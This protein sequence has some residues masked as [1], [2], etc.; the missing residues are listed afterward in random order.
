MKEPIILNINGFRERY[1]YDPSQPIKAG[2]QGKIYKAKDRYRN[3]DV[4]IKRA[5][6]PTSDKDKYS[7]Y[8]EFQR[9]KT[10]PFHTNLAKYYDAYRF[11]TRMGDF[12][13][14]VMEFV[15]GGQNLDDFIKTFPSME[16]IHIVLTGI[17]EGIQHLHDNDVIHRDLKPANILVSRDDSKPIAKIIDFGISKE[18][19]RPETSVSAKV[20]TPEYMAPEQINNNRNSTYNIDLWSYGV[21]LYRLLSGEMPFGS[22]EN[23][24]TKEKIISQVIKAKIPNDIKRI[25][26]PYRTAIKRCLVKDNR[27]RAQSAKE[28]LDIL[29]SGVGPINSGEGKTTV[30][31]PPPPPEEPSPNPKKRRG[32]YSVMTALLLIALAGVLYYIYPR[33]NC[34]NPVDCFMNGQYYDSFQLLK[35]IEED[36]EF[37]PFQDYMMGWLYAQG[38]HKADMENA[39]IPEPSLAIEYLDRAKEANIAEA[40]VAHG[41]ILKLGRILQ[42]DTTRAK[43]YYIKALGL[44]NQDDLSVTEMAAKGALNTKGRIQDSW[45]IAYNHY[46]KAAEKG[47]SHAMCILGQLLMEPEADE[48]RDSTLAFK[49]FESAANKGNTMGEYFLGQAYEYGIGVPVDFEK[50]WASYTAAADKG[51]PDALCKVGEAYLYGTIGQQKDGVATID[52][53]DMASDKSNALAQYYRGRI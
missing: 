2:G 29:N 12:D 50:A 24:D 48:L 5:E 7:V 4:A 10:I 32:L 1:D 52:Y 28:I 25:R 53:L 13:F 40:Y 36:E 18:L 44:L 21:I 33:P 43:D 51:Y 35:E 15:E 3:C 37:T 22:V 9:A 47:Y 17:L 19:N 8:R 11:T 14:G 26:E 45:P 16:E 34:E 39:Y 41:D 30:P 42:G 49:Y 23:N 31:P 46:K 27:K 38:L 20:G 6:K